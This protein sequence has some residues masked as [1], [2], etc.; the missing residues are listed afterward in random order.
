MNSHSN[1]ASDSQPVAEYTNG[2]NGK[3]ENSIKNICEEVSSFLNFANRT[4]EEK[5]AQ[6][7]K[8]LQ[9]TSRRWLG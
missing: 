6:I 1:K 5:L 3:M 9:I 7:L 8:K 2:S 4:Q